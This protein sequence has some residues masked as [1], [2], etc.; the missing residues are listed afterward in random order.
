MRPV[1][2]KSLPMSLIAAAA[3]SMWLPARAG[4]V[5]VLHWWTSG[6]EAKAAAELKTTMQAKGH[7]WKDFAVA[8]GGGDAAMTV[9]K[10]RVVSGN[11]PAAAQIKGPSMQEWA[12]RR[13]AGQHR[14]RGQGREV[15]RAAAQG[16]GRRHEVQGQLR[17]RAGQRAPRQLA[18]GQPG[19]VQEGRRQAADDLGRVL[20]R[21]RGAEEGR[22][23]PGR[24]RWPELA[25]LHHLRERWRWAS[26][27]PISTRRR[28]CK[29]DPDV[30]DQPD[31]GEGARRPSSGSRT[32]PTRTPPAAT[33][34]WPPRWSS[35]ARPACSSWATGP[36]ANSS[37]PAR[38]RARTSSA[39]PRPAPPRPT[40]STSTRSRCSS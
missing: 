33:G 29:L 1:V 7:T 13:R 35:R 20:R 32:T 16:R 21:R 22:R 27:A 38:C 14:R 40:P 31:D 34:T 11:A 30:A 19:R 26:A 5:E 25:G 2:S 12:Q 39:S 28:W 36:R 17:R 3:A 24:A 4:E 23:D 6:G 8:G 15:G 18:V 37:P 9:L 10:S